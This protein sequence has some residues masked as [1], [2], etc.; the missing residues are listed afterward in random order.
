MLNTNVADSL[1]TLRAHLVAIDA[2]PRPEED[3]WRAD[4][5]IA[6]RSLLALV[7]A[8]REPLVRALHPMVQKEIIG[9]LARDG[10]VRVDGERWV[11]R[12]D[13][14]LALE[15]PAND[16]AATIPDRI[17]GPAVAR[18]LAD[19]GETNERGDPLSD[20]AMRRKLTKRTGLYAD[21]ADARDGASGKFVKAQVAP[22]LAA[23]A[24]AHGREREDWVRV[25]REVRA[26]KGTLATV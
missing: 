5:L 2:W 7:T 13:D 18:I 16:I 4:V 23:F 14:V 22:V 3:R 25:Y 19:L 21:L 9:P 24:E 10:C 17:S 20:D 6:A 26:R 11:S 15:T 12:I 8:S 1:R